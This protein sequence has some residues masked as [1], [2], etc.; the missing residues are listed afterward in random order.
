MNGGPQSLN[1][2]EEVGSLEH[3]ENLVISVVVEGVKVSLMEALKMNGGWGI[4]NS[5]LLKL[6]I[7]SCGSP[8][9]R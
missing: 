3:C 8:G 6:L 5:C 9:R 7:W 1:K 2:I 4:T